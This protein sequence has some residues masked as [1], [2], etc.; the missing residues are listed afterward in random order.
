LKV[1]SN[2]RKAKEVLTGLLTALDQIV[3]AFVFSALVANVEAKDRW[4][5]AILPSASSI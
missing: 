1:L 3:Q 4:L 2:A 5:F